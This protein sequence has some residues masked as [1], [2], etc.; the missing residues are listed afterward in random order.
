[1]LDTVR[2]VPTPE[3]V[4]LRLPAAGPLLRAVA[5]AIDAAIRMAVLSVLSIVTAALGR[6]GLG[7]MA[8]A[9]FLVW[10]FYPIAF[11]VFYQGQT[12]GK[13]AMALRVVRSDGAPVGWQGSLVRNLLRVVDMLPV[14]YAV[15]VVSG[16]LDPWGRRLGDIVAGT[17]VVHV[18][19]PQALKPR[20]LAADASVPVARITLRAHEQTALIAFSERADTLTQ[21]RQEEL[22]GL[23]REVT[24]TDGRLGVARLHALADGWLGR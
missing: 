18:P 8:V 14:G 15:G 21:E 19:P 12:P 1:M 16:F 20:T 10:W 3:G 11:E 13:R 6:S 24:G 22:A 5:W 4:E 7:V 23:V 2:G 17:L 9:M